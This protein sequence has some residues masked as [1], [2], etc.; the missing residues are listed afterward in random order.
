MR[1]INLHFTYLLT[2]L[3]FEWVNGSWVNDPLLSV[4]K[5]IGSDL[6]LDLRLDEHA[7]E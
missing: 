1:Y 2:Y 7:G 4:V 6:R 3:L 5:R